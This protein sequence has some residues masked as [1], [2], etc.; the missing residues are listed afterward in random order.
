MIAKPLF[1]YLSIPCR[2]PMFTKMNTSC[3]FIPCVQTETNMSLF[4]HKSVTQCAIH[5]SKLRMSELNDADQA[6]ERV[7][8]RI[9]LKITMSISHGL[10]WERRDGQLLQMSDL[11]QDASEPDSRY[12]VIILCTCSSFYLGDLYK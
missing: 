9:I 5:Q 4:A 11:L 3:P 7:W 1:Y 6:Q 10:R 8:F 12:F 2:L